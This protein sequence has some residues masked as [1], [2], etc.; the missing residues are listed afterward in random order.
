MD[1]KEKLIIV[2]KSG[3]GKDFALMELKSAGLASSVKITT[4]PIRKNEIDGISYQ[5]LTNEKFENLLDKNELIVNQ[6][7]LNKNNEIW[8]YG[9]SRDD[10]NKS[11]IFIMTPDEI[12]QISDDD[13]KNC[14]I[15][16]LDIDRSI[17]ESRL[18]ERNDNNDSIIRRMDSD[19]NDFL[20]FKN[21]DLRITDPTFVVDLIL[22]LMY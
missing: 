8:K 7:F 21:Y 5:F 4:R 19:E 9:I 22:D 1:K 14:F 6:K 18:I 3:S 11:Q 20:N 15:V 2:G 10:F 13:R 12:S 17:R 16:Y